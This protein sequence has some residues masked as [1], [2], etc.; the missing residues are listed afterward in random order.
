MTY[1]RNGNQPVCAFPYCVRT[2]PN[3]SNLILAFNLRVFSC[4]LS[5]HRRPG[6]HIAYLRCFHSA[7]TFG[8]T[9]SFMLSMLT[10]G[11]S[12]SSNIPEQISISDLGSPAIS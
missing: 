6:L 2:V 12:A 1:S 9:A 10:F 7:A 4:M 11:H 3:I 5:K 8:V